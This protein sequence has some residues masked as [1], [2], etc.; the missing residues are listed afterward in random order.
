MKLNKLDWICLSMNII[1][2]I[3]T[4]FIFIKF[5]SLWG[6]VP[7]AIQITFLVIQ[8]FSDAILGQD[9]SSEVSE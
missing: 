3:T 4:L 5:D 7:L 9:A 6:L 1:F 2:G 8:R